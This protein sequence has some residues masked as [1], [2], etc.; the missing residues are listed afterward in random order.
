[1]AL[2]ALL[3][4][5]DIALTLAIDVLRS[6]SWFLF[7]LLITIR[8]ARLLIHFVFIFHRCVAPLE[9]FDVKWCLKGWMEKLVRILSGN[10]EQ[11]SNSR[12]VELARSRAEENFPLT[13][14]GQLLGAALG[15][16]RRFIALHSAWEQL[17]CLGAR[18]HHMKIGPRQLG[19]LLEPASQLKHHSSGRHHDMNG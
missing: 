9:F 8:A 15:H 13:M 6:L 2:L 17:I 14:R 18:P 1:L 16:R 10:Q 7:R 12:A 19:Q 5:L 3:T 4:L 11:L